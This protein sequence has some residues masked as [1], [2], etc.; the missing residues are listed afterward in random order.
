M[1][2]HRNVWNFLEKNNNK[3]SVFVKTMNLSVGSDSLWLRYWSRD[4]KVAGLI[5]L[6]PP[7]YHFW[8]PEHGPQ[9]SIAHTLV[10]QFHLL[11]ILIFY[12]MFWS[13]ILFG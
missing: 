7:I 4:Q 12:I 5:S 3:T 10:F 9:H 6:L 2:I 11:F 13:S 1:L 8:A